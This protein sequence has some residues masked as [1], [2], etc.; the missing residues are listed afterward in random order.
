MSATTD[1]GHYETMGTGEYADYPHE[2]PY[3]SGL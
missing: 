1:I 2:N 3:P